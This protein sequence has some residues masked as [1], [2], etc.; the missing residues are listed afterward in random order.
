MS[1]QL[2]LMRLHDGELSLEE[3]AELERVLS[4]EDRAVLAGLEQVG[5]VVRALERANE[6]RSPELADAVMQAIEADAKP[7]PV[8]PLAPRVE[9]SPELPKVRRRHKTSA[10]VV[11]TGL[12][13]AAAAAAALWMTTP[14]PTDGPVASVTVETPAAPPLAEPGNPPAEPPAELAEEDGDPAATIE[15][16]DFGNQG[17][18][19]FMVPAGQENTPVVWLVDEPASARMEPL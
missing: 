19:I 3:A 2:D 9:A 13:L 10:P 7:A 15:A 5:D 1:R 8:V 11:I 17:G 6:G 16:V 14:A 4:D 12:A 18:S